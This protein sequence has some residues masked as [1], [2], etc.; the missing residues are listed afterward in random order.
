M[1]FNGG[2]KE[3]AKMLQGLDAK[4]RQ[5]VMDELA[6]RDPTRLAQIKKEMITLEDLIHLTPMM[7]RDLMSK[8]KLEKLALAL[9]ISSE[10]L[11]KHILTLLSTNNQ[12]DVLAILN[13]P[14]KMASE[15]QAAQDEIVAIIG[16]LVDQGILVLTPDGEEWV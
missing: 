10:E 16:E 14:P 7:M 1:K 8:I 13:G 11:K 4:S 2:I 15:I 6:Q 9:R 3:A 5:R 12:K